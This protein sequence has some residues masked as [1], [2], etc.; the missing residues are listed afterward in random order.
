MARQVSIP[1]ARRSGLRFVPA[2]VDA[3]AGTSART[4]NE[5]PVRLFLLDVLVLIQNMRYLP[6]LFLPLYA[7]NQDSELYVTSAALYDG[8]P[9]LTLCVLDVVLLPLSPVLLVLPVLVVLFAGISWAY[10]RWLLLLPTQGPRIV[11]STLGLEI[12]DPMHDFGDER[13]VFINGFC[14]GYI[15]LLQGGWSLAYE[16]SRQVNLQ[17]AIDSISK[18]FGRPV[19][20]IHNERYSIAVYA[21]IAC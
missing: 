21:S 18:T 4:C 17:R 16:R 19:I 20:G 9:L 2:Q 3:Y 15:P 7:S 1:K 5:S 14:T 8:I 13:W 10:V 6:W 11:R 12:N